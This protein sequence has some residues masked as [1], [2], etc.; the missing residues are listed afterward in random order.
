MTKITS[1]ILYFLFAAALLL[2]SGCNLSGV[3]ASST[4]SNGNDI[5]AGT[6]IYFDDQIVGKVTA[7]SANAD[8][9]QLSLRFD[10]Q[11]AKSISAN[12]A[13]LRNSMKE[14]APLEII[15]RGSA[16]TDP[17][18]AGQKIQGLDSVLELGAWMVGDAIRI[19]GNTVSQY[20]EAFSEYLEGDEFQ[21]DKA[22]VQQ[23]INSAQVAAKEALK[24]V[25]TDVNQAMREA[26]RQEEIAAEAIDQLGDE[27]A[28]LIAELSKSGSELLTELDRLARELE[29]SQLDQKPVGQG[30]LQSLLA[31]LDKLNLSIEQGAAG[32]EPSANQEPSASQEPS[33]NQEPSDYRASPVNRHPEQTDPDG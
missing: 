28:P 15:N 29:Q 3:E 32:H 13:L 33:A 20:V 9:A 26:A 18:Q 22:K 31:A 17:L 24:Q 30:L 14:G 5:E 1:P 10:A 25:E 2:L 16:E 12:S 23:Q 7:V 6:A 4:L 19:G 21:Q 8:G 27:L 11:A